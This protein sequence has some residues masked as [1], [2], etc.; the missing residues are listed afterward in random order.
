MQTAAYLV[1]FSVPFNF[2]V[3]IRVEHLGMDPD[4]GKR[5]DP[6]FN[7]LPACSV[8]T[9][10]ILQTIVLLVGQQNS[11]AEGGE[12]CRLHLRS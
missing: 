3:I 12:S 7:L 4:P 10:N 11:G 6:F 1:T 2:V 9:V 8:G 5:Q